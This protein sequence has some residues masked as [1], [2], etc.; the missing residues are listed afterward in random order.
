[1]IYHFKDFKEMNDSELINA[2]FAMSKLLNKAV[3]LRDNPKYRK[4]FRNQPP[5]II[6]P[7]FSDLKNAL[8]AEIQ[9]RQSMLTAEEM[10]LLTQ[11]EI[12]TLKADD[13]ETMKKLKVIAQ[14]RKN[15][16]G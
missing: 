6:N 12:E 1:M 8:N 9:K 15:Q 3:S 14:E 5:P 16:N 4:K 11:D 10:E 7:A 2:S 13:I